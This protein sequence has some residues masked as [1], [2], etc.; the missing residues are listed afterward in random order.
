MKFKVLKHLSGTKRDYFVDN[1]A[2][3]FVNNSHKFIARK[4]K[5]ALADHLNK[6]IIKTSSV[7]NPYDFDYDLLPQAS[8][9]PGNK[10]ISMSIDDSV[11][12]KCVAFHEIG[13]ATEYRN[14]IRITS[15]LDEFSEALISTTEMLIS[16][17]HLEDSKIIIGED[18]KEDRFPF[19]PSPYK[20]Y[21]DFD[22]KLQ[23]QDKTQEAHNYSW[24]ISGLFRVLK[25][26]DIS[27]TNA[28]R[29]NTF[30]ADKKTPAYKKL[31]EFCLLADDQERLKILSPFSLEDCQ[32]YID[33]I[34]A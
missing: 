10:K 33:E 19:T 30:V 17:S 2:E 16:T 20:I 13:H 3:I 8:Y 14:K 22:F 29:S 1:C 7:K 32:K 28:I 25:S 9:T 31:R 18:R 4:E 21:Y 27:L 23:V 26:L 12:S 11:K 24:N 34:N 6:N 15:F 5:Q